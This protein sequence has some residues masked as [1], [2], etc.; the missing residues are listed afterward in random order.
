MCNRVDQL[1][2]FHIIG[3]AKNQPNS[4]GVYIPIIKIPIK[5]G[6]TIP[7]IA[8]FDHGTYGE[9]YHFS[10]GFIDN[11]WFFRQISEPS[12]VSPDFHDIQEQ[13]VLLDDLTIKKE[14]TLADPHP[15]RPRSPTNAKTGRANDSIGEL[16]ILP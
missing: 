6:M 9:Y 11:R 12:T 10:Q 14:L 13:E 4:V 8:T 3:D 7:N 16:L 5:G 2:Y 15:A 1:H